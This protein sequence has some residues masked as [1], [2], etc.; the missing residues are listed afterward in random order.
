[1]SN[2]L[3]PEMLIAAALYEVRLLLAE[4]LGR[5][6]T[7][8]LPVRIAAHLAYALH[9]DADALL[10]GN[11]FQVDAALARIEAIDRILG[12]ETKLVE[13]LSTHFRGTEV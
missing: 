9:N 2:S 1:M 8:E 12:K 6:N 11:Q 10:R 5:E 3:K 7:A 4:Y 13:R